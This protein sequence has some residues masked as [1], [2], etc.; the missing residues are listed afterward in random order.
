MVNTRKKKKINK[1]NTRKFKNVKPQEHYTYFMKMTP[2]LENIFEKNSLLFWSYSNYK[3]NGY[4]EI[5]YFLRKNKIEIPRIED[6]NDEIPTSNI[7]IQNLYKKSYSKFIHDKDHYHGMYCKLLDILTNIYNLR[8]LLRDFIP[9]KQSFVV[10][11]GIIDSNDVMQGE[12][13]RIM[14]LRNKSDGFSIPYFQ[15]CSKSYQTALGFQQCGVYG[16]CCLYVLHVSKDVKYIPFFFTINSEIKWTPSMT[17][18]KLSELYNYS[19][20]EIVLEPFVIYKMRKT[21][22]KVFNMAD[23]KVCPYDLNKSIEIQVFEI[24]VLPPKPGSYLRIDKIYKDV[25]KGYTTIKNHIEL[26]TQTNILT[27]Y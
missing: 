17:D 21:Y 26:N 23:I 24:N 27:G 7:K 11:R 18:H 6:I 3:K 10:Y 9:Y 4:K 19:E 1:R 16:P 20:F 25:K 5:N 13:E 14:L 8:S 12:K 2:I 15:S 22:K